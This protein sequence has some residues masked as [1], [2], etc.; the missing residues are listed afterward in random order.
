MSDTHQQQV[1]CFVEDTQS[2]TQENS[3][4]YYDISDIVNV[5]HN[6]GMSKEKCCK[7]ETSNR[8][9]FIQNLDFLL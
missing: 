1:F 4:L 5:W 9:C 7:T 2:Q 3:T 8:E 6:F